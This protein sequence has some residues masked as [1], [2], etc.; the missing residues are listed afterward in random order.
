M[1][2]FE[3]AEI[4]RIADALAEQSQKTD[5]PSLL[6][7]CLQDATGEG[8]SLPPST[9]VAMFLS[10]W[11]A[12]VAQIEDNLV[13]AAK[14]FDRLAKALDNLDESFAEAIKP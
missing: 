6:L 5:M 4:R 8:A 2:S 11:G 14:E 13:L 7:Y 3:A 9:S 10:N 1:A 12:V